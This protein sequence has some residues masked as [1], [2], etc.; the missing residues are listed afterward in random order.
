MSKKFDSLL[1]RLTV[2]L[3]NLH[4]QKKTLYYHELAQLLGGHSPRSI[5]I[6]TALGRMV[7]VDAA[8]G[9]HLLSSLIIRTDTLKPGSGYW[10]KLEELG[11]IPDQHDIPVREAFWKTQMNQLGV[12]APATA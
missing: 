10:Y 2:I 11:L 4:Q 9:K 3:L 8:A 12:A 5:W 7:E 6:A 1:I